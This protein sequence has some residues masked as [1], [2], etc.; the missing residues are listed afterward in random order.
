M[1]LVRNS[2]GGKSLGFGKPL[3]PLGFGRIYLGWVAPFFTAQLN[4]E[5]QKMPVKTGVVKFRGAIFLGFA[6]RFGH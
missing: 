6:P 3:E 1:A 5:N 2:G 4:Q